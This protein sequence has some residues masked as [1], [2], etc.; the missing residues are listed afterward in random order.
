MRLLVAD[1][2]AAFGDA[3][4]AYIEATTGDIAV[5]IVE[6]LDEATSVLS[7]R[8]IDQ[9]LIDIRMPG[10]EGVRH[11]VDRCREVYSGPILLISGSPVKRDVE[12]ALSLGV[13]GFVTKTMSAKAIVAA[14]RLV[15][16]GERFFPL[17]LLGQGDA[18]T[19][20]DLTDREAVA[21]RMICSGAPNKLIAKELGLE[22]PTIKAIVRSLC[23]KFNASNRTGVA[24]RAIELGL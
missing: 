1:D 16:S 7:A 15:A 17:S 5:T 24:I 20:P 14:I 19:G 6:G 10:V 2:H 4:A 9:L 8:A 11:I 18:R 21:L 22:L 23:I 13:S 3:L 12:L